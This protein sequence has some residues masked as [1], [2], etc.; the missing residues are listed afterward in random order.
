MQEPSDDNHKPDIPPYTDETGE[1]QWLAM[2]SAHDKPVF[3][4]DHGPVLKGSDRNAFKCL[5]CGADVLQSP[6][7]QEKVPRHVGACGVL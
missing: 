2:P 7:K 3:I 4:S 1:K 6:K 5:I